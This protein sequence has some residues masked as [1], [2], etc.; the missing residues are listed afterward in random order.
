MRLLLLA[1]LGGALGSG[2]RHLVNIG[3]ARLVGIGFPWGTFTVNIVG[4]FL[5]GLFIEALALKFQGS[6]EL[7]TFFA[8]GV[9][10]GFTTFSAFTLDVVQ[11][12]EHGQLGLAAAYAFGSVVLC[13][14]ALGAGFMVA[15]IIF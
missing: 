13:I 3:A 10:G 5:M 4:A 15:R 7:R 6:L 12:M 14:V 9:L 1:I 11:M 2:A 8:T